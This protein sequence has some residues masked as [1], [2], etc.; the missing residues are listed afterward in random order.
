MVTPHQFPFLVDLGGGARAGFRDL[1]IA[2]ADGTFADYRDGA[3]VGGSP[4]KVNGGKK[5]TDV[6]LKRGAVRASD[7]AEWLK[8]V[9]LGTPGARRTVTIRLQNEDHAGALRTWTLSGARVI[10]FEAPDLNAKGNEVAIGTLTLSG[11]ELIVDE[12]ST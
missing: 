6:T 5:S 1:T 7:L 8:D 11:E 9:R 4:R 3:A 12:P 10:K 2:S